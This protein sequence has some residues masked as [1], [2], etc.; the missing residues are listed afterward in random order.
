MNKKR[1]RLRTLMLFLSVGGIVLTSVL[2]LSAL[3]VFQKGNIENS[4][5]QGNIAY[6]RKLADTTDRYLGVAQQELAYS[7]RLIIGL[8]D[9]KQLK[10]EAD[11][12]RMQSGFFN[13]VV[14]VTA[15][16]VIAATSPESLNL[17]GL[18]LHSE[19]SKHAI[20]SQKAYISPPFTSAT[21]NY[22]VFISQPLF[23]PEGHYI[24]FI[25]GTIYLKKHS[26]LSEILGQ[27]FYANQADVSIVTAE[28]RIL[29]S[30]D[31]ALIGTDVSTDSAIK[32]RLV[33]AGSGH[34]V[35]KQKSGA[36]LIGYASLQQ[37]D[38]KIFI[39]GT[40]ENV[41]RILMK[42]II[43]AFWFTL[44]II[45]LTIAIVIFFARRISMPL[46]KLAKFT[47]T[48]DSDKALKQ[49]AQLNPGYQEAER[50][51]EAV[52]HHLE[53]MS[54]QVNLLSDE[55]MT[56]PLTGLYNRKGFSSLVDEHFLVGEHCVIAI[57]IDHFKDINDRLGHDGGDAVLVSFGKL[58]RSLTRQN[59]IVCRFGGEEFILFLPDCT[60]ETAASAVERIRIAVSETQFPN[61]AKVTLSAG[62][63]ALSDCDDISQ[64]L[65][66]ADL[67]MYQAKGAGRNQ[68]WVS[69]KQGFALYKN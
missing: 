49:L 26:M 68:V 10:E 57:D 43:N 53:T 50:L 60:L 2:L 1:Y 51:R 12:L 41:S 19:A 54:R 4:L 58:L 8:H 45:I 59:D 24:G 66:Q 46:E 21:G 6:A 34:F 39:S 22:V 56:D 44:G 20:R 40:S 37:A 23:S 17:V 29:F 63:A 25:G 16:A 64:L 61:G 48:E 15:D 18:T 42:T 27:H 55:A 35:D 33:H 67:A 28:G 36:N 69:D 62:V 7:A 30:D 13:S 38:W 5:L 3:T 11:R 65:R 52:S 14:I 32:A 47:R 9:R 31:P